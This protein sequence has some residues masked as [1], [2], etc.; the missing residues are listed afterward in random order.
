M[1]FNITQRKTLAEVI[2]YCTE[3][4]LENPRSAEFLLKTVEPA[5]PNEQ[6]S[7]EY[8]RSQKNLMQKALT[9]IDIPPAVTSIWK[10]ILNQLDDPKATTFGVST[11]DL[12]ELR[13][14][15]NY[16]PFK[17][18][19]IVRFEEL[20]NGNG[21][22]LC[23]SLQPLGIPEKDI[24]QLIRLRELYLEMTPLQEYQ[25]GESYTQF[26]FRIGKIPLNLHQLGEAPLAGEISEEVESRIQV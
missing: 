17:M 25:Y 15:P 23:N 2:R 22:F 20:L 5:L 18:A 12:S 1:P 10:G 7:I 26:R 21:T 19:E 3:E 24:E 14:F 6:K 11:K 13:K 16:D 4:I 9:T 8:L